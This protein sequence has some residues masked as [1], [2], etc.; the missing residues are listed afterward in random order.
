[1]TI[2]RDR[3]LISEKPTLAVGRITYCYIMLRAHNKDTPLSVD[4]VDSLLL[5][6]NAYIDKF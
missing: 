5:L 1:M 3:N 2:P 6:H 4:S